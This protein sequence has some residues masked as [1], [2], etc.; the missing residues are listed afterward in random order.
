MHVIIGIC[1]AGIIL[2]YVKFYTE[3]CHKK[4]EYK[5]DFDR[6]AV[7]IGIPIGRLI[8]ICFALLALIFFLVGWLMLNR[9]KRYYKG[10]YKDFGCYLWMANVLLTF[11]LLFR[12][13]FDWLR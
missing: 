6:Y 13:I 12:A 8:W 3:A 10:F 2:G 7:E 11:P 9:L 5:I 1:A 4:Q